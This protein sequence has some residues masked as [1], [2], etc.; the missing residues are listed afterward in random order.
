MKQVVGTKF[1]VT[2][3][4]KGIKATMVNDSSNAS[5]AGEKRDR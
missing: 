3:S 2:R 5:M 4:G 1:H